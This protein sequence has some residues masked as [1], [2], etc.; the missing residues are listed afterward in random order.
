MSKFFKSNALF[1]LPLLLLSLVHLVMFPTRS[2]K[3]VQK[4]RTSLL[5]RCRT[6]SAS[7]HYTASCPLHYTAS[8]PL[9][10]TASCPL[11]ESDLSS[12]FTLYSDFISPEEEQALVSELD[13]VFLRRKYQKGHWDNAIEGYRET[14]RGAWNEANTQTLQRYTEQCFSSD[15]SLEQTHVLDLAAWG[16]IKP[17]VD[18][19]KFC[20]G[21]VCGLSLLS[22]A[23][24]RFVLDEEWEEGKVREE[25]GRVKEEEGRVREEEGR[26]WCE[27]VLPRRSVYVMSGRIR[28]DYTHEIRREGCVQGVERGRRI[29]VMKR[30]AV[31]PRRMGEDEFI[32]PLS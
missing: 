15:V 25:E 17:H 32:A 18:S 8:C 19:I 23:V 30:S 1:Q 27:V 12:H 2:L 4:L 11:A 6:R 14:E 3:A 16:V 31:V 10:Y 21:L 5:M 24:M 26:V 28:Y 13:P 20:G 7:L 9:H 29:T 22:D